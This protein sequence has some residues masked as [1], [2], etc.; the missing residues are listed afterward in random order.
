MN[1][2]TTDLRD[3][4]EKLTGAVSGFG[5]PEI[6]GPVESLQKSSEYIG[7]AWSGSW[8]GY[9]SRIYYAGLEPPPPGAHFS[10][11]WGLDAIFNEGST[12]N[13]EEFSVEFV[14]AEIKK[15]AGNPDISQALEL[16]RITEQI[17][18]QTRDDLLSIL[19][20]ANGH[21]NDQFL[22][23][24]IEEAERIK[25]NKD[26][27]F[28]DYFRPSGQQWSRDTLAIQQGLWTPPHISVLAKVLAI[29]SPKVSCESLIK[30]ARRAFS[31]MERTEKSQ[32]YSERIG[33]NVFIGHGRS[34][35][36]KDLKDFISDR[37]HLP[38]DEFNRVPVAGIPNAVRLSVMLD[39]AAIALL[40]LRRLCTSSATTG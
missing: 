13:W 39:A 24:L 23:K 5:K 26:A 9:H 7:K 37:M 27:D 32:A 11:E 34:K 21:N 17:F 40:V 16:S 18:E 25:I 35:E 36:W 2:L 1:N 29:M 28:I 38:W 22:G 15:R 20:V 19:R 4:H 12:G 31:H 33:T 6:I 3:M 30:I 10:K 14:D 8:F